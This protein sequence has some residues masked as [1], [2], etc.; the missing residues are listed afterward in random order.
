MPNP[1]LWI[2]LI[3]VAFTLGVPMVAGL[4]YSTKRNT[5]RNAEVKQQME[6]DKAEIMAEVERNRQDSDRHIER[7]ET[8]LDSKVD[9]VHGR[10]NDLGRELGSFRGEVLGN[11]GN[12]QGKLETLIDLQKG[13]A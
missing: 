13:K 12:I 10:I 6:R 5:E 1:G 7:L 2:P 4:W 9:V 11:Q 8:Q 3:A